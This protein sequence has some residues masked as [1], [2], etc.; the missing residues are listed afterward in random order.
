M[1]CTTWVDVGHTSPMLTSPFGA[2]ARLDRTK[3][4]FSFLEEGVW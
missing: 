3:H 1:A 4:E 2:L